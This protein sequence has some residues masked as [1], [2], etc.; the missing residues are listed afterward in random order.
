MA[1]A[2][3]AGRREVHFTCRK[4]D[5]ADPL[6][7]HENRGVRIQIPDAKREL[8][9]R[10]LARDHE[11]PLMPGG[12]DAPEL[13]IFPI[14]MRKDRLRIFL[15]VIGDSRPA[16]GHLEVTPASGGNLLGSRVSGLPSP[17]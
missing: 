7:I 12:V 4:A 9:P 15:H 14:R 16:A 11:F 2:R 10:P 6:S 8:A 5:F 13:L 1:R 3:L 17:Q